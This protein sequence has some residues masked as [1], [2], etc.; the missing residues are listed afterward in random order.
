MRTIAAVTRE[1]LARSAAAWRLVV[2]VWGVHLV[3]AAAAAYPF[4]RALRSLLGPLPG[5]D[6][7][8]TGIRFEALA[9]LVELRP[10]LLGAF[11]LSFVAVAGLGLLIGAAVTA[12]VLEVLRGEDSR[13]LG[14]RFGRGAGRFFGRFVGVGLFV[15]LLAGLV[16]TLVVSPFM[17]LARRY[18]QSGWDAARLAPL[19]GAAVDGLVALLALLVFDA[20]RIHIVRADVGAFAGLRDGLGLVLRHP[21]VWLGTWFVNAALVGLAVVLF[22]LFRRAVP[23]ESGPQIL[24]MVLVQQALVLARTGL[25]VALLASETALVGRLRPMGAAAEP[26]GASAPTQSDRSS[27]SPSS[28]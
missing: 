3:L 28:V 20:A 2:L 15:G 14:H 9:D 10:G 19:A 7:L 24:A 8:R 25:R 23:T 1:G 13:P 17:V 26:G 16:G 12:G 4:W 6:V 21:P 27:P 11:G 22:V 18:V 5:A